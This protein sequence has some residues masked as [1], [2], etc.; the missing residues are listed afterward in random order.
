MNGCAHEDGVCAHEDREGG[1]FVRT[2]MVRENTGVRTKIT[3][4]WGSTR[5]A[6]VRTE[7]TWRFEG[8]RLRSFADLRIENRRA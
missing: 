6:F 7:S 5:V 3:K 2:K 8:F 1:E 4:I